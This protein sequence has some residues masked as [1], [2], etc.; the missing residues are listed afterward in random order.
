MQS[1]NQTT[2][3][4]RLLAGWGVEVGHNF[5]FEAQQGRA[6]DVQQLIVSHFGNHPIVNP[7]AN[8]RLLLIMPR[9]IGARAKSPQS[10]DAPKVTELA[11]TSSEGVASK[12][13]GRAE[14]Q[15]ANIPLMVAVEKGAIQGIAS[16]RGAARIVVVGD[17]YFL[18]NAPIEVEANRD[19]ARNA[20]NWLLNR[21]LL[22]QGI[23]SK[24]I[25][26]YRIVMTASEM[27][28]VRWLFIA[29]FPGGVLLLGFLVWFRRRA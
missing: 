1:L 2:G 26:E 9:S 8:S 14:R 24:T 25:K 5:V 15:G 10:A 22:V 18:A 12:P 11:M 13:N 23:G 16:D 4:E 27:S 21:D 6:G 29:G 7:L 3:L 17:S 19:F 28:R 20:V